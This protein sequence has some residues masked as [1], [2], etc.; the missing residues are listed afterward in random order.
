MTDQPAEVVQLLGRA[1]SGDPVAA[2]ARS[3]QAVLARRGRAS[4][5]TAVDS[6]GAP[7]GV[8]PHDHE[9]RGPLVL[10]TVDGGEAL[11]AA[12]PALLGRRITVVHHGSAPGSD[13]GTLR[14]LRGATTRAVA[15]DP[16]ARE[17]LRGLGF[18]A[19][20][21]FAPHLADEAMTGLT[22][23]ED[24]TAALD[25]HPGPRLLCV[26]PVGPNRGLEVLLDA[27][28]RLLTHDHPSAVLSLCGPSPR[29]YREWLHRR[30]TSR[31]L[32]ACEVVEPRDD[33]EVLARLLRADALISLRPA[34][35]DPYLRFAAH[36]AVP[37]V[38]PATTATGWMDPSSLVPTSGSPGAGDLAAVLA[39]ALDHPRP[40]PRGP[41]EAWDPSAALAQLGLA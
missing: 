29:W 37:V 28:A 2:T 16:A 3:L 23:D 33:G 19:V 35:P 41:A 31:G 26:G 18:A 1:Q 13:R 8:G 27:F 15:A 32:V 9:A 11:A 4:R 17:E 5:L 22:A 39:T 40:G 7:A 25:G 14:A 30:I 24:T 12:A 10:H 38:A 6:S 21:V 20:G 36:H 34:A